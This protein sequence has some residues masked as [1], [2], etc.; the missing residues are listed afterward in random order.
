MFN[1]LVTLLS[2]YSILEPQADILRRYIT[3]INR[4]RK[5]ESEL[6]NEICHRYV[7]IG[8]NTYTV[9]LFAALRLQRGTAFQYRGAMMC[10][11]LPLTHGTGIRCCSSQFIISIKEPLQSMGKQKGSWI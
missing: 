5:A 9:L 10:C 3:F 8:A 1:S 11:S 6:A 4:Q 7:N 2:I